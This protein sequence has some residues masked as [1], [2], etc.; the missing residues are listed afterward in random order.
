MYNSGGLRI[1]IYLWNHCHHQGYKRI[2]HLPKFLSMSFILII[3][4]ICVVR[5][6]NIRSTLFANFKYAVQN[7]I[8]LFISK[9]SLWFL[10]RYS[11][12]FLILFFFYTYLQ[13]FLTLHSKK[14]WNTKGTHLGLPG[15]I[16]TGGNSQ[17]RGLCRCGH[18]PLPHCVMGHAQ[19]LA[20][21]VVRQQEKEYGSR[22]GPWNV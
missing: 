18:S 5:T 2:Y 6:Q 20:G 3:N 11:L 9:S 13:I 19:P 1:S 10:F 16:Y 14:I 4:F 22:A 17:N 15:A 12:F 8:I 21:R 7:Y